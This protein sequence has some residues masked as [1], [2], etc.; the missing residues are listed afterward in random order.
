[1][2]PTD[3]GARL[4][5]QVTLSEA[6]AVLGY[7]WEFTADRTHQ[8]R[9]P[10]HDD[11][12][13]SARYYHDQQ[14]I[15]CFTCGRTWDVISLTMAMRQCSREA[16]MAFLDEEFPTAE[17]AETLTQRLRAQLRDP[18]GPDYGVLFDDAERRLIARR[19]TLD[20]STYCRRLMALDLVRH[21]LATGEVAGGAVPELIK[22]ILQ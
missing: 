22:R 21:R 6:L 17:T 15:H 3:H 14:K 2:I 1:M 16:A 9:C 12:T 18:G 11:R 20:L 5:Q 19:R 13:P 4:L 7:P 8:I 10:V